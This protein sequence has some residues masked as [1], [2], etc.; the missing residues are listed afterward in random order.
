MLVLSRKL[1]ERVILGEGIVVTV[2]EL[3]GQRV[4]IGIEAP[5]DVRVLR[6]ELFEAPQLA[7]NVGLSRDAVRRFGTPYP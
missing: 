3:N 7:A 1:G 2:T 5:D 6:G 4:R